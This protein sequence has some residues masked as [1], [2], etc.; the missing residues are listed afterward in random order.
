MAFAG[1]WYVRGGE[2]GVVGH[3]TRGSLTGA[4]SSWLWPP[5]GRRATVVRPREEES[6]SE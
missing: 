3:D 1:R 2:V 5:A 4:P 6:R